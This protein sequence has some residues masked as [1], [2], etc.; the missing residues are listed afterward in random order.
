MSES[1]ELTPKENFHASL[2]KDPKALF[3]VALIRKLSYLVPSAGLMIIW[4]F[5]RDP[6]YAIL[7]YAILF[8]QAVKSVFMAKRGIQ[9]TNRVLQKYETAIHDKKDASGSIKKEPNQTPEPT[10]QAGGSS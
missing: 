7:G 10:R 5:T 8:Y 6:V 4:L 3:R 1:P 2:F 9:T